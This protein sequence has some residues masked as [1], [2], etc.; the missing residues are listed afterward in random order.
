MSFLKRP[1][2]LTA[3]FL[4]LLLGLIFLRTHGWRLPA[5]VSTLFS[6]SG[7]TSATPEERAQSLARLAERLF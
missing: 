3:A 7:T 2:L 5:T 4:T 1:A 6:R